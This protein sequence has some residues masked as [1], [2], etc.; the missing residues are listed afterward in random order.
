MLRGRRRG[1]RFDRRGGEGGRGGG[2]GPSEAGSAAGTYGGEGDTYVN[3]PFST[4]KP[5]GT[6]GDPSLAGTYGGEGDTYV[7]GGTSQKPSADSDESSE[8]SDITTPT[9]HRTQQRDPI[10]APLL[11]SMQPPNPLR[12]SLPPVAP[13][14]TLQHP[15]AP[16]GPADD[17]SKVEMGTPAD[18]AEAEYQH[19]LWYG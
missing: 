12:T 15:E 9:L 17:E 13:R 11:P 7:A 3:G 18:V 16:G 19:N 2:G 10:P 1:G 14:L 4:L 8:T 5:P 6:R